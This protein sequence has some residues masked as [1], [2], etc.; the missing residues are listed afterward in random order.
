MSSVHTSTLFFVKQKMKYWW[1]CSKQKLF[2][3]ITKWTVWTGLHTSQESIAFNNIYGK[4]QQNFKMGQVWLW[5]FFHGPFHTSQIPSTLF[6]LHY[7][8]VLPSHR[9]NHEPCVLHPHPPPTRTELV[10]PG[11]W[12]LNTRK[13]KELQCINI[14]VTNITEHS[15]LTKVTSS[16][17]LQINVQIQASYNC[18]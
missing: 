10:G 4:W 6:G 12:F 7:R 9:T 13:D 15:S 14:V 2:L 18:M 3:L 17:R 11:E 1:L 5:F 16:A 8:R